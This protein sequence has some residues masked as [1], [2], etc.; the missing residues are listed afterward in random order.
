ME[1]ECQLYGI[2]GGALLEKEDGW[3]DDKFSWV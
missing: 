3:E 2:Y 1:Q